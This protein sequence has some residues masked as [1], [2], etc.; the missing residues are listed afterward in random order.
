M[1]GRKFFLI[2]VLLLLAT[3]TRL[4]D[5][6]TQSIWFDEGWSAY[7]AEQPSL[8]AA[9][10]ADATNPPLYYVILNVGA[11]FFGTS[12]LA[13]RYVSL[14]FGLLTI[15]LVYQLA[16]QASSFRFGEYGGRPRTTIRAGMYGAL[17]ATAS[18]PLWWASQEARMYTL[19]AVLVLICMIAWERVVYR[20]TSAAWG[21]LWLAE[22][23]LLYTHNTGPVVVVWLNLLTLIAWV[24]VHKPHRRRWVLSQVALGLLWLPYFLSRFLLLPAANSAVTSAPQIGLALLWDVWQGMVIAPWSLV[25]AQQPLLLLL[26]AVTLLVALGLAAVLMVIRRTRWMSLHIF[27]LTAGLIA[28]LMV[29]GNELHGRYLVMIVPLLLA[30]L[31]VGITKLRLRWMRW[32]SV[33][34][35]LLVFVVCFALARDPL[36]QHDDVRGMVQFY[37]DHLTEEDSVVAWSYADRYDLAYY[38]E[39]LGVTAKRIT[40]PEGADLDTVLPLLDDSSSQGDVAL[41]VWFTQRADY[42]GMM[43]CVLGNG[44]L[45]M[46]ETFTTYGMTTLIYDDSAL[47]MPQ[48]E[49]RELAFT[50]GQMNP[51]A[52]VDEVGAIQRTTAERALCL[53]VEITLLNAVRGDLK[54][55]LI[56]QNDLGWTIASTDAIFATANQRTS[57][58]L[59]AGERLAAYPL[60]RLP[61]GAP[62]GEYRIYLRLY[63]EANA[64]SGYM[65]P[66]AAETVG[67]DVLLGTWG[68]LPGADWAQVQHT[69]EQP[70]ALNMPPLS[71]LTLL[72]D[73]LP[74]EPNN[75][76]ANGEEIRLALL[77]GG[78]GM[79]PVLELADE[80]GAWQVDVPPDSVHEDGIRLDWRAVRVPAEAASG[81]AVLRF[82]DGTVL[83]RYRVEATPLTLELPLFEH[84]V[85]A[86]FPG[87][88]EL[89]GYSSSEAPFSSGN[90]PEITLVWRAG[91][92]TPQISYTVTVQLVD[93]LGQVIA[94][95]DAIPGAR[96]TTGWRASDYITDAH[97]LEFSGSV[98]VGEIRLLAAVYD[99]QTGQRIQLHDGTDA[100]VLER[101]IVVR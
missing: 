34:P 97:R 95:D 71:D 78:H 99:A 35:F 94:Q 59:A 1:H 77:W 67:R 58:V 74:A 72:A 7:A 42:R 47:E 18:A 82:R 51:V 86:V 75:L 73:N 12:E 76:I 66:Q 15:P 25:G 46:P 43:G 8:L 20:P 81:V 38:W 29:L 84:A 92:M 101:G 9:W 44:T 17:L 28:G 16:R 19:V 79:L 53:P 65:P 85:G 68:V 48:L 21:A 87:L 30:M 83:A 50:D 36:Y 14:L 2:T 96:V 3:A 24:N 31:A 89:V 91:E 54:A 69:N 60:L 26:A 32:A 64:P 39:R 100:V 40:L 6:Q 52:R 13:L 56:V 4:L 27:L 63:D 37:A 90:P 5:I 11:R 57:S 45:N 61:Y 49:A 33:A 23:A 88:G 62:A 10:N 70:H 93:E 41:N 98:P 55:A 22:L 80:A